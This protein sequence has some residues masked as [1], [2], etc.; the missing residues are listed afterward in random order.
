MVRWATKISFGGHPVQRL[1]E[2]LAKK[3]NDSFFPNAEQKAQSARWLRSERMGESV[4]KRTLCDMCCRVE[5]YTEVK[6]NARILDDVAEQREVFR[7]SNAAH[8]HGG[9]GS[10]GELDSVDRFPTVKILSYLLNIQRG[11]NNA[12]FCRMRH[13]LLFTRANAALH[14]LHTLNIVRRDQIVIIFG[15]SEPSTRDILDDL[16]KIRRCMLSG[17]TLILV[18]AN[19]IYESLYDALNQHYTVEG[20]GENRKYFT[21]LTMNGY[22]ASF[23][24]HETFR[25]IAI[26]QVATCESLLPPF[27]NRFSKAFLNYSSALSIQ[28]RN[29]ARRIRASSIVQTDNGEEAD[30]LR[31]LI[32]GFTDD[33]IDSLVLLFPTS[34]LNSASEMDSALEYS[35]NQ[36]GY[37]CAPRRLQQLANGMYQGFNNDRAQE[38]IRKWN[39][40]R[41][42]TVLKILRTYLSI[43]LKPSLNTSITFCSQNS[44]VCP[45][46]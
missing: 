8:L 25:C 46:T 37:L 33:T 5:H 30:I 45:V 7:R 39:Q 31:L 14:L 20:E 10:C 22:T 41:F 11:N 27:I 18:G 36:L 32:P 12:N 21:R 38:V 23:P 15:R 1:E 35:T 16:L 19:H 44:A 26:E 13:V 24:M 2:F 17:K 3:I 4:Q 6:T 29:L 43:A 34:T 28:Q 40:V 9:G 42:H